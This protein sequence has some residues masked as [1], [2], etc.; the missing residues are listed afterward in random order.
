[1]GLGLGVGVGVGNRVRW[2]SGTLVLGL[3]QS[4]W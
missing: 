4:A 2:A 1:M 3:P